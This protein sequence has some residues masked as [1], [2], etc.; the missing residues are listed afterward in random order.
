MSPTSRL[1]SL[2]DASPASSHAGAAR[3]TLIIAALLMVLCGLTGSIA[4]EAVERAKASERSAARARADV[5]ELLHMMRLHHPRGG[6]VPV[7]VE[8]SETMP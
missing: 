2:R 1:P 5:A 8:S 7:Y 3:L 6:P 4:V